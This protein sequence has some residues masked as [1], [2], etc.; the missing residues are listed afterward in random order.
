[1]LDPTI[2]WEA[3]LARDSSQDGA[4]VYAVRST[5]IFCRPSCPSRRP[6]REQVR[7]FPEPNAA[8]RA[9]FRPCQRCRPQS[10]DAQVELIRRVCG[11]L[12]EPDTETPTLTE[13]G[14]RFGVSPF[15]LQR[16]FKK[17]MGVSPRQYAAA[18]RVERLK[19]QLREGDDVTT[20]LYEAGYGSS[21]RLYEQAPASLGMT[22]ATYKRGGAGT[23]IRYA[24]A[25][26][27]LG[28]LLVAATERGICFV[29]M[30]DTD[31]ELE[32]SLRADFPVAQIEHDETALS[33][34]VGAV[35][36]H[37]EGKEPQ[38]DLPLD[39]QA[40]AFQLQV[41]QALRAI[42]AGATRSYGEIAAAIGKPSA[43]RAVGQACG[44]NPVALVVPCHRV[45]REGGELGGYRWGIE[46]KRALLEAER[47]N[48]EQPV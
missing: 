35:V 42:P 30:G 4:F 37:L 38:L 14:A 48:A 6:R 1:M 44:N 24:I 47:A 28:R 33:D 45:V 43:A 46:R 10:E 39:V 13:L 20:A 11:A 34:W 27:R 21:S 22:P 7:F 16:T 9:G 32:A 5:G 19:T 26:S 12:E 17:I 15:H 3:V 18:R 40:T 31:S 41:W 23:T 2:C 29:S 8:T 25:D 36:R